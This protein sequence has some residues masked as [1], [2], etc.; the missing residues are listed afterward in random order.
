MPAPLVED[1]GLLRC[2]IAATLS[3]QLPETTLEEAGGF[4]AG[5]G[6]PR[7]S[8]ISEEELDPNAKC[9][10]LR[11]KPIVGSHRGAVN[12]NGYA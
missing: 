5:L 4:A 12:A 10:E 11:S 6:C 7:A 1:A 2:I 3:N 9:C 8:A